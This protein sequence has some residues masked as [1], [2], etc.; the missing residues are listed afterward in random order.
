MDSTALTV[1]IV[2]GLMLVISIALSVKKARKKAL[3]QTFSKAGKMEQPFQPGWQQRPQ[4]PQSAT[5][6]T[7]RKDKTKVAAEGSLEN[8]SEESGINTSAATAPGKNA[9]AQG[10]DI[11][12][13]F[14]PEKM[15]IY[16]EI[17][18]PGY[19]KY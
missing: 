11:E 14:D 1:V 3:E 4:Q 18:K 7:K 16:S 10:K 5:S 19:E 17:I 8:F 9:T 13:D 15:I 6:G 2:W 12:L